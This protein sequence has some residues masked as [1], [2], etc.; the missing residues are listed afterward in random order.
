MR[1]D[2]QLLRDLWKT[3]APESAIGADSADTRE[4]NELRRAREARLKARQIYEMQQRVQ[5]ARATGTL[6]KLPGGVKAF[7]RMHKIDFL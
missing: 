2:M 5:R 3:I 4:Q 1:H 6:Y 7:C